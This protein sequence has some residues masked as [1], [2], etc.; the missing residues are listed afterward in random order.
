VV[1]D[2]LNQL[3]VIF[4]RRFLFNALLP[5][6]VF[7]TITA[8]VVVTQVDSLS[9]LESE[10]AQADV[11]GRALAVLAYL[12]CIYFLAVAVASQWRGIV[13][14]FEGYTLREV[15]ARHGLAVPGVRWHRERLLALRGIGPEADPYRAYSAYPL[16]RHADDVLPTRLGNILLAAERYSLDHY[17]FES[18]LFWPRL[19]PLLPQQFQ[20]DYEEF[21]M[22]HE[23]PLVVAFEAAVAATICGTVVLICGGSPLAFAASFAGGFA[24]AFAAYRLSLAAAE[25]L[26]EQQRAA[27]DLYRD[28]LLQLWPSVADVN[29]ERAAFGEIEQF[30]VLNR[31]PAWGVSQAA[32]RARRSAGEPRGDQGR[33]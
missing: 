4:R 17:C 12:A 26:G 9:H 16:S 32:H 20:V 11:F 23:F 22:E 6:L 33:S 31:P 28:R 21:L 7:T 25:E 10:W 18:I 15:L 2:A 30:V 27:V 1:T 13:R 5:T 3:A 29:D 24:V 19:Y 8:A 14:L